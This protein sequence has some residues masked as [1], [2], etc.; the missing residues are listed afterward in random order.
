MAAGAPPQVGGVT[1]RAL[2]VGVSKHPTALL[3]FSV[4]P[5]ILSK[6]LPFLGHIQ[7]VALIP[8]KKQGKRIGGMIPCVFH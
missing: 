7:N 8:F 5:K 2:E 4:L 1:P 3:L 6:N